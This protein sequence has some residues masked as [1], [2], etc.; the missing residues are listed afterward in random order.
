MIPFK[1]NIQITRSILRLEAFKLLPPE[2][3]KERESES[4]LIPQDELS[5]RKHVGLQNVANQTYDPQLT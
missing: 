3:Q 1:M 2:I 4:E 5:C